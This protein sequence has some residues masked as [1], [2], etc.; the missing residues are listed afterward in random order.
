[1]LRLCIPDLKVKMRSCGATCI[2]AP[3]YL[4]AL[5]YRE[6]LRRELQIYC[7]ALLCILLLA[8]VDL[9]GRH[10][11]IQMSIKGC[12]AVGV[13]NVESVSEAAGLHLDTAHISVCRSIHRL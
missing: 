4:L 5:L 7:P 3:G 12:V 13:R 10:Q 9:K 2:T 8:Q 6:L 1:M 11:V